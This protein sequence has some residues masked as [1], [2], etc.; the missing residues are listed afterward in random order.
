M[1]LLW[2]LVLSL[3]LAGQLGFTLEVEEKKAAEPEEPVAHASKPD[4][5]QACHMWMGGVPGTPGHSGLP[6]RDGR[7]GKEGLNG[8]KGIPGEPGAKGEPGDKGGDGPQGPRGFPG[9][10]GLKGDQ[11]ESALAP[12]SAFSVGLTSR[13]SAANVPI[14]FDK[15]FYNE[16][17]HYDDAG[18]KFL[19]AFPGVY[20]FTYHLTIYPRDTRVSLYR[21]DKAVMFTFDQFQ[22]NNLDQASGS[23]ILRLEAGDKVWLQVYGEEKHGG[24]YADN[25][26]DSTFSGFLLYPDAPA[27]GQRR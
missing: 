13:V 24:I 12:R 9:N 2:T 26:N 19:C 20:F 14:C 27:T 15:L 11:V 23:I 8:E 1:N 5:R 3:L 4:D 17:R 25:T 6:G 7:D 21:N 16:Q 18:G 22:E 10:P